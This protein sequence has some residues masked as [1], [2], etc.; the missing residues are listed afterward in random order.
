MVLT[1]SVKDELFLL[2]LFSI[3]LLAKK[4]GRKSHLIKEI[5]VIPSFRYIYTYSNRKTCGV[6]SGFYTNAVA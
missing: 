2:Q 4:F 6:T 3:N 1:S 5:L